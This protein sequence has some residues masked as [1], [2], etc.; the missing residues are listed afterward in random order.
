MFADRHPLLFCFMVG[1]S[2]F[3]ALLIAIVPL[4][5][6]YMFLRPELICLLVIYW[7][8]SAPEHL[9]VSF[10]FFVGLLQGLSEHTVWGAHALALVIVAYI[11]INAYQRIA[12]YSVWHQALWV[13]VLVGVHQIVVNWV[14]SFLGYHAPILMLLASTIV[15]ALLW[16]PL[17]LGF[18][19]FR[20]RF[21]L[22]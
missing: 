6:E 22:I 8:I 9:G 3:L 10:A 12:S 7:V 17:L 19:R 2:I 1:L 21:Q 11:C 5:F 18:R 15:S 14:Q 20:Q 16:P 4:P 13:C